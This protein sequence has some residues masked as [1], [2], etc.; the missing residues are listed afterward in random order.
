MKDSKEIQLLDNYDG[1]QG[2]MGY[3]GH[4]IEP[5]LT[6]KIKRFFRRLFNGS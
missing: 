1:F 4:S 2:H 5:S 3:A 6:Y